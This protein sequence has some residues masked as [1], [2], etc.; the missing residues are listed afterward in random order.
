MGFGIALLGYAC[1]LLDN[2]GGAA[3]GAILLGYGLFSAS[4]V[5]K[6]FA[7]AAISALFMFPRGVLTFLTAFKIIADT[8]IPV[9]INYATYI[10]YIAA[11]ALMNFFWLI[12]VIAIAKENAAESLFKKARTRLY[13]SVTFAFVYLAELVLQVSGISIPTGLG[14]GIMI[15]FI[16]INLINT[17]FMHTCFVLITS[18]K[19]YAKDLADIAR[20]K[21]KSLEKKEKERREE[22]E[23][24]GRRR[25]R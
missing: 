21:A 5:C 4:R 14:M 24:T 17:L 11:W 8:S 16:F 9:Y 2:M 13:I 10:L 23:N 6:N 18:E 3:F 7:N 19:Q 22:A 25:R 12:G 15:C 1:L 20:E